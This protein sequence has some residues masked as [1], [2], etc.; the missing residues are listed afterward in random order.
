M[1][2]HGVVGGVDWVVC[3]IPSRDGFDECVLLGCSAGEVCAV[4]SS[5]KMAA[6]IA[7]LQV[8]G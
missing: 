3:M 5:A 8:S 2:K 1:E 7:A 6:F 4:G